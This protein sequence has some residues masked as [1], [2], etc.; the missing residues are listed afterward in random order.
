M[1]FRSLWER[2]KWKRVQKRRNDGEEGIPCFLSH[3]RT[4]AQHATC[5]RCTDKMCVWRTSVHPVQHPTPSAQLCIWRTTLYNTLGGFLARW[6]PHAW[7]QMV[8]NVRYAFISRATNQRTYINKIFSM[9]FSG[10]NQ[11][12][13][14]STTEH[15]PLGLRTTWYQPHQ[16]PSNRQNNPHQLPCNRPNNPHQLPWNKPNTPHQLPWN[17][18]STPHQLPWNKPN[19]LHQLSWNR[20]N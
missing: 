15:K 11:Y 4:C 13:E 17:R 14:K 12:L 7:F 6:G 1:E 9:H 2:E 19:T 18:P 5:V 10:N 16:L 20:P 8:S 3:L